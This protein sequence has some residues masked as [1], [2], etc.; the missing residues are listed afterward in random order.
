MCQCPDPLPPPNEQIKKCRTI[1]QALAAGLLIICVLSILAGNFFGMLMYLLLI[2]LLYMGWTQF[3]WCITLVFFLFCIT[4]FIQ[5]TIL[6]IGMYL[7]F[8]VG[9]NMGYFLKIRK[10]LQVYTFSYHFSIFR[11]LSTSVIMHTNISNQ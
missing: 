5:T 1:L 6:L 7:P 3:N 4:D 9:S 8:Y 10:C 11:Q 2:Y